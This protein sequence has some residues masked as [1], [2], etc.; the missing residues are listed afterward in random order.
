MSKLSELKP[1]K[2]WKFGDSIST[3][4]IGGGRGGAAPGT[5]RLVAM[6]A[7]CL[8]AVRP[9][10]SDNVQEGD[11]LVAGTNFGNGS[12]SPG[13][14]ESFQAIGLEAVVA[15]SISR[16]MLRTCI[17]KGVPAFAA[18]GVTSIVE[19][20]DELAVDYEKGVVRNTKSGAEVPIKRYPPTVEQIY[21]AG[22]IYQVIGERLA[23]E[24]VLPPAPVATV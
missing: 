3:N 16:L 17:A 20:G 18:P 4:Q 24:G 19:D 13:A 8:R 23:R 21:N 7:N 15:D 11:I 2:V 1:G 9:E 22:G 10:F 6:K 5:D 14:V 12:S